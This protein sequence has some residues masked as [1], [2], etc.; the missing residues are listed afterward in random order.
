MFLF[1]FNLF[2]ISFYVIN[3]DLPKNSIL[4]DVYILVLFIIFFSIF[5]KKKFLKNFINLHLVLASI[6]FTVFLIEILFFL[7]PN[8]IPSN[9]TIW[10]NKKN[11]NI[12][13]TEILDEN[14]FV[15]F[16]PNTLVQTRFYRGSPDQFSYN[17]RTDNLGFKNSPE[18]SNKDKYDFIA[19]GDSFIEGMGV[20]INDTITSI[21]NNK[22]YPSYNFGVQGYAMSQSLGV[23]EK[24]GVN[25]QSK[26]L[27]IGYLKG[28]YMRE[29]F[30]IQKNL[31]KK[32][33]PGGIGDQFRADNL[34]EVRMQSKYFI[35]AMWLHTTYLRKNIK[36]LFKKKNNFNYS[37][38]NMYNDEINHV[39]NI[40]PIK[41][42][43]WK[44]FI[45]SL[46]KIN[47][48]AKNKS[49]SVIMLFFEDRGEVYYEK[50]TGKKIKFEN[51]ERMRIKKFCENNNIIFIDIGAMMRNYVNNL[52][53]S[54]LNEKKDS[55][56]KK[57]PYLE[58]DGHLSRYG[59]ELVV[60]K[61]LEKIKLN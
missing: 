8:L 47:L 43:E 10:I 32:Y 24:Y 5:L 59:N 7:K 38:F 15:K 60:K 58:I 17:W 26:F 30:Q 13:V 40:A 53:N 33:F 51:K 57:L 9:L 1:F 19:I 28:T 34:E 44:L 31:N 4:F 12:K 49:S 20:S 22:G 2:V 16:K 35:N 54:F 39:N 25:M 42:N 18:I 11:D 48:Q 37:I 27:I 56:I 29:S 6:L 61:L 55:I 50:A 23:F 14:P 41:E 45:E 3:F 52:E 21:L 46:K 36:N